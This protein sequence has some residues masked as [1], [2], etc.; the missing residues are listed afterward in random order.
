MLDYAMRA[1]QLRIYALADIHSPDSFRMA[2]LSP[3]GKTSS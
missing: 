2:Q 1:Q 3:D